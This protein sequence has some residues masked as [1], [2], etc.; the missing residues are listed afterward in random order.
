MTM[1][2]DIDL[3]QFWHDNTAA[4]VDPFS[5]G[6][7]R[8]P[9][10]IGMGACVMFAELGLAE[11]MKRLEDDPVWARQCVRAYNDKA[12]KIVGRR[13]MYEP[14]GEPTAPRPPRIRMVGEVFGCHRVRE[15]QSWW[16]LEAAKTPAELVALLD[17]AEQL[18]VESQMFGDDFDHRAQ[19]A[20]DAAG[21]RP[22]FTMSLRGPVTLATSIYGVENL[23]FLLVDD[24]PLA[25]RFRD[26][27]KHI[28][29][30]YYRLSRARH[31][32]LGAQVL[33]GFRFMDDNCAMLTPEMYAFFAQ[34]IVQAVYD[35][36]SPQ[37]DHVRYQH[38]DSDMAHLLPVLAQTGM[39]R[40]N[41]GPTVRFSEIRRHM[42]RAIVEG[43]LAP[44]T[45]MRNDTEQIMGEVQR[46]LD[47]ARETRGLVVATAGSVNNGSRLTSLL[48][49]MRTIWNDRP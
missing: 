10:G 49:V 6:N 32:R 44:F 15:S 21:R 42:P 16:L 3:T 24:P 38:S 48:T 34:P 19:Q 39:N 25:A 47:E 33:P 43:T 29:L 36:F 8:T 14:A 13:L 41:F 23:V 40:V 17:R 7:P 1:M 46:D 35:E 26:V 2:T 45:F 31:Q 18:D 22:R 5:A 20:W 27:L 11:D 30:Q 28:I 12:E 37:P 4:L 9:M